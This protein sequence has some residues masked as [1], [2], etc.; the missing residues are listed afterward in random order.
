MNWSKVRKGVYHCNH[1]FA[2]G[3]IELS[4]R[5]F[6][7]WVVSDEVGVKLDAGR[8]ITLKEAKKAAE[9]LINSHSLKQFGE[10]F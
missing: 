7:W 4:I 8:E 9:A 5:G 3:N 6:W 2:V 10:N 1:G